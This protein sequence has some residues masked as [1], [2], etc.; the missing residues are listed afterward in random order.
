M[1]IDI[2]QYV[3]TGFPI[4][5]MVFDDIQWE[6]GACGCFKKEEKHENID[7]AFFLTVL[8]WKKAPAAAITNTTL[9]IH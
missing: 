2:S 9:Q 5:L 6:T 8:T 7:V 1:E 4:C 3:Q